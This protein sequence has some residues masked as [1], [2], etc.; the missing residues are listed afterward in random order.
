LKV[1][2]WFVTGIFAALAAASVAASVSAWG[3]AVADPSV[4]AWS[5]AGFVGLRTAVLFALSVCVFTRRP[6]RRHSRDAVAFV[7]CAVALSAVPLLEQPADAAAT[8][9]VVAGDLVAVAA[10]TWLLVS[11]AALGRCFGL[12]PEARGLVT[13][14]PYRIVRHPVYLGEFGGVGG[15]VLASPTARNVGLAIAFV[16]AQTVRL[17]LEERALTEEFPQYATYAAGTPRLLPRLRPHWGTGRSAAVAGACLL[18]V[19][20]SAPLGATAPAKGLRAPAPMVPTV[21]AR[22]DGVP[23]FAWEPVAGAAQYEFQIA[24]DAGM[25]APVLGVGQDRFFTKN[26]RA[27]IK[28]S[29]PDR[30]YWWRVRASTAS[31]AVS[32]W[33]NPRAFTKVLSAPRPLSPVGGVAV[34]YPATPLKLTWSPVDR[35]AKYLVTIAADPSLGTVIGGKPV[36]TFAAAFTRAGA[37][38]P[39]TYYWGVTPVDAQGNPGTPSPVSSFTWVWP[40][41]T[42]L[43]VGDLIAAPEAFDPQLSWDSIPGAG[44]YEVEVNPSQDFAPGSKVCCTGTTIG[45]VYS[46]TAV[47]KDNRYYWRVRGFDADGNPGVWNEGPVFDKRFDK[48]PPVSRDEHQEPPHA[49]Q[50]LGSGPGRGSGDA[51][52]RNARSADQLGSRPG[53]FQLPGGSHACGTER[54]QLDGLCVRRTLGRQHHGCRVVTAR[55]GMELRQ[56]VSRPHVGRNR[57]AGSH[58]I[59]NLLRTRSRA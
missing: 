41:T 3:E 12:L 20:A 58:E 1:S 18:A 29:L 55:S 14:G 32:P 7:A 40:S 27:T 9:L 44:R 11:F 2:K 19:L 25:N 10:W 48:V 34:S 52:I 5:I 21:G 4:R 49:G 8:S 46:P 54:V 35:A 22:T 13:R 50:P 26:T 30:T 38:A 6:P 39:G 23:W 42:S 15:L 53:C 57:S 31:G 36:E 24:A 51:G 56:A 59:R 43:R 17:R 37:L 33:T 47:L 16:V 28:K 45:T